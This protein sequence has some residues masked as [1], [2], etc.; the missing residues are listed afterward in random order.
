MAGQ[1]VS[2]GPT[3][4]TEGQARRTL[5]KQRAVARARAYPAVLGH[6][7]LRCVHQPRR[8]DLEVLRTDRSEGDSLNQA[9]VL[10]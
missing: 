8:A 6:L 4:R 5:C 3:H 10:V 1:A 2:P 9:I 7:W